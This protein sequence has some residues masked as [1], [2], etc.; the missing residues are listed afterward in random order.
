MAESDYQAGPP[1]P[2]PRKAP[3]R[4]PQEPDL[5]DDR[6]P[7]EDLEGRIRRDDGVET[8]I[9]YRNPQGLIAYYLGVFALIPCVGLLVGPADYL[10]WWC[11]NLR[12]LLAC[13]GLLL[14]PAALILG[15]LGYRYSQ[16]HPTARGGGHAIAGIVLGLLTALANWGVVIFVLVV[17]GLAARR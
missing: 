1:E 13:A 9:P 10:T 7:E 15:I 4:R 16:R 17:G 8:F 14:G 11:P 2:P 12:R 5:D 3:A 6:L